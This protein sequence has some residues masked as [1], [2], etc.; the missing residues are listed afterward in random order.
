MNSSGGSGG[1]SQLCRL[2]GC[3]VETRL[4]E[5]GLFSRDLSTIEHLLQ[6]CPKDVTDR[7]KES[8]MVDPVGPLQRPE[9]HVNRPA[10]WSERPIAPR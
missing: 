7:L 6:F 8:E 3:S 4:S 10:H 2:N 5:S 1:Q 9:L